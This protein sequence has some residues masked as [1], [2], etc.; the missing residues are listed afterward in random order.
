MNKLI[1]IQIPIVEFFQKFSDGN[2]YIIWNILSI[3]ICACAFLVFINYYW[4]IDK[5]DGYNFGVSLLISLLINNLIK[6]IFSV[7]RPYIMDSKIV[8]REI[9]PFGS[10]KSFPS[11]HVAL[12]SASFTLS[13]LTH[14][15]P[16]KYIYYS[17]LILLLMISRITLGM[18]YP[19]DVVLGLGIGIISSLAIYKNLFL[20]KKLSSKIKYFYEY[21]SIFLLIVSFALTIT[22]LYLNLDKEIY[23][24]IA[25]SLSLISSINISRF[26]EKK[27]VCFITRARKAKKVLRIILGLIPLGVLIYFLSEQNI[28]VSKTVMPFVSIFWIMFLYPYIGVK[29]NLFNIK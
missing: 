10:G 21:F 13:L 27:V 25:S 14:P 22:S 8:K 20:F 23:S 19:I 11:S 16:R 5:N 4:N 7:E 28:I 9:G 24:D 29:I 18:H 17:I 1:K 2:L 26:F 6:G 3:L 12:T 15:L